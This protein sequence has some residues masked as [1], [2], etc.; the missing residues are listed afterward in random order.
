MV[1]GRDGGLGP[2]KDIISFARKNMTM[3]YRSFSQS[4]GEIIVM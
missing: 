1:G 3:R 4:K 2:K